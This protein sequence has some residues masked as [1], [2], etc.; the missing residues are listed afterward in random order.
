M[1]PLL[2]I[3]NLD[4]FAGSRQLLKQVSFAV[5]AGERV[6]V[7]GESGSG[8][9]IT[10]RA[11]LRLLPD[12]LRLSS[13]H[14]HFKGRDVAGF[15]D[16]ELRGLRGAGIG[17]VFQEPMTSLN[18]ALRIGFQLSEG[19]ALHRPELDAAKRDALVQ[20][21][22]RRI[23]LTDPE[24][25]MRAYPHEFS[26]GMRQRIMLASVMLVQPSLL[27][28]DE[29][30]TALDAV[31][32][33]D[34]LDLM[35]ELVAEQG[36]G[37]IL[38][39]HDLPIVARY[40]QRIVVMRQG[41]VVEAGPTSEILANP[42]DLYTQRLLSALPRKGPS[43]PRPTAPPLLEVRN[44]DVAYG[45]GARRV[46]VLHDVTLDVHPGEI[47]ALVGGS[48]SGKT[49][50]GRAISGLV[51]AE[52]GTI[53]LNGLPVPRGRRGRREYYRHC[54]MIFQDPY[55]SLDPRVRIGN[56][57]AESL[58]HNPSLPRQMRRDR[59]REMLEEVGLA[60]EFF[61][62]FPHQLSGGQRQRVAIAR[63]LV[64]RPDLVVADE[65]VSALDLT[66]QAQVLELLARLQQ[67]RGFACLFVTHDL[68]VVE[69]IAD[70]VVVMHQGRIVESA[71]CDGLFAQPQHV[72]TQTLLAAVPRMRAV[73]EKG[74]QLID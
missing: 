46:S 58:R 19:L 28:A 65:A 20:A 64:C 41:Q 70:R 69:Q 61:E 7:V 21:M 71:S 37:L 9:S 55:A 43:R 16:G 33:K 57:V 15:N 13:G 8:K 29:P 36:M 24:R 73:G 27:I 66:V 25:V 12:G 45:H 34:V 18:P 39:S 11:I 48:G 6:G 67:E 42:R 2:D 51:G 53:V 10:S 63:A 60:A 44:V 49:T 1:E 35:S 40:T 5:A 30:T 50:L 54:Q 3:Q 17:M 56:T 72:Y 23:G 14:I 22:L 32:Q 52:R 31:V 62:R 59:A 74:V 4:V 68:G 38:V 26:G 47:V